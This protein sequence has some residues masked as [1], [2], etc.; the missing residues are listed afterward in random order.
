LPLGKDI[1]PLQGEDVAV[2][3]PK[4]LQLG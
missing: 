1:L 3:Q 4:A 2:L